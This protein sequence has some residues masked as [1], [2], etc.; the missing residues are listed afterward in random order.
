MEKAVRREQPD[1]V[2]HL[3]DVEGDAEELGRRFPGL[4]IYNV[5]GNCDFLPMAPRRIVT[6]LGGVRF[7]LAHGHEHGVK[8]GYE[9]FVNTAMTAGADVALFGHT[10]RAVCFEA[11]GMIVANPGSAAG[12]GGPYGI[13]TIR[14][15]KAVYE[16]KTLEEK[17]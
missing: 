16:Q 3:G 2:F 9:K 10:H 15:G 6:E 13:V 17:D 11:D 7:F 8:Y 1:A 5:A 14:D 12:A 4:V